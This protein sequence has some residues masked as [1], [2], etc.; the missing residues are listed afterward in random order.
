MSTL[1]TKNIVESEEIYDKFQ[2]I[3]CVPKNLQMDYSVIYNKPF[4]VGNYGWNHTQIVGDSTV[5]IQCPANIVQSAL[6]IIP[7][8]ASALYRM[9][10]CILLQVSGTPMHSGCCIVAACPETAR[11][12]CIDAF[13]QAPHV[14]LNANESTSVC[15]EIPFYC[16]SPLTQTVNSNLE[17]VNL[18]SVLNY[19]TVRSYIINPLSTVSG[20]T[21]LT[22]SAHVIIKEIEFYVP[23]SPSTLWN[24]IPHFRA[25]S[26]GDFA[27]IPTKIF[28]GVAS[29]AKEVT[30]DFIDAVRNSVRAFTGFHNPNQP[31]IEKRVLNTHRN[32]PNYTDNLSFFEK[33]T[34]IASKDRIVKDTLFCT[35]VDEMDMKFILSKP[36]YIGTFKLTN[37]ATE[38]TPL[39]ARPITPY[40]QMPYQ[41]S[42]A[43]SDLEFSAPMRL[44]FECSRYWRGT[45]K[46]HIQSS[47]TNF[48]YCKLM[49]VKN[50]STDSK[51]LNNTLDFSEV[52][53]LLTDTLEFSAGGQ[54]QTVELPYC[55]QLEQLECSKD[56]AANAMSH[57]IYTIYLMQPLVNN[58]SSPNDAFFNMYM[59]AGDDFQ[60]YGY[61]TDRFLEANHPTFKA[62]SAAPTTSSGQEDILNNKE[63]FSPSNLR[64][65]D[66]V[67]N[68]SIRDYLRRIIPITCYQVT[69]SVLRGQEGVLSFPVSMLIN[70][71]V[72]GTNGI[73]PHHAI[74]SL[75]HGFSGGFKLKFSILGPSV[76]NIMY[77]PPG[78]YYNTGTFKF[79]ATYPITPY[80][81]PNFAFD[82]LEPVCTVFQEFD[83]RS[84]TLPDNSY[85]LVATNHELIIPNMNPFKFI[86]I[87]ETPSSYQLF[88]QGMGHLIFSFNLPQTESSKPV[89]IDVSLGFTDESRHGF[90]TKATVYNVNHY[91]EFG[92]NFRYSAYNPTD[93]TGLKLDHTDFGGAYFTGP[94]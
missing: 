25:E 70:R 61:A 43:F 36:C 89:H 53:N 31:Q 60:F 62:E 63:Q 69:E 2:E 37:T 33:M 54:I 1:R 56:L 9:K 13:L 59:S 27:K 17:I 44:F 4:F 30:G 94:Q 80:N 75:Y 73:T 28:D 66:F 76:C 7:F 22:I 90:Q 34:N 3:T 38:G 32:F 49:V 35:D 78:A 85:P 58:G 93:T 45:L 55:S 79:T 5:E 91:S 39:F 15:L 51:N 24:P 20:T 6:A 86:E 67:P 81:K 84:S 46:L 65:D 12:D 83:G 57:G 48:Q 82:S 47:M 29:G 8:D 11:V 40:V 88:K 23:K 18:D 19:A 92:N 26:L 41:Q 50:Y 42:T 68:V 10:A 77:V 21:A 87:A 16:S 64:F 52:H 14:F 72:L 74:H 71:D